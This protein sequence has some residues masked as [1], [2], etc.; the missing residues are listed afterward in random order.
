MNNFRIIIPRIVEF[1]LNLASLILGKHTTDGVDSKLK[2]L[3][4]TKM[5]ELY[6]LA[7]AQHDLAVQLNADKEKAVELRNHALGLEPE[8]NSFTPNTVLFYVSSI[9][10]QLLGIYKG[11]EQIMG[12]WGFEINLGSKGKRVA[13]IPT[14]PTF[15]I[16]LAKKIQ[17]KHIADGVDS[18]LDKD[19]MLALA[20]LITEAEAQDVLANQL[21]KDKEKAV[22]IRDKAL[23]FGAGQRRITPDTLLYF[24]TSARDVLKGHYRGFEQT[25]GDWG[26]EVNTSLPP[27][28]PDPDPTPV[29][30]AS[31]IGTVT[32]SSTLEPIGGVEVSASGTFGTISANTL[33]N[34]SYAL[35]LEIDEP[36]SVNLSVNHPGF[37]PFNQLVGVNSGDELT[38]D[39]SLNPI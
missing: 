7:R 34:G 12:D 29:G 37:T 8:Q 28:D 11:L 35:V 23:G 21:D 26:F 1:F 9:R 32:N 31:I 38:I 19:E 27:S 17:A 4:M 13:V 36:E 24:V 10:D 6:D 25:L 20:A 33:L 39:I 15:L 5:Q 30:D 3:D 22:Q 18:P 16:I 14:N 2:H